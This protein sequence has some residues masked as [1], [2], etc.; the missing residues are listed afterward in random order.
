M[1]AI[2]FSLDA[3]GVSGLSAAFVP[4][5]LEA[6]SDHRKRLF[7]RCF[8]NFRRLSSFCFFSVAF[9]ICIRHISAVADELAKRIAGVA[10]G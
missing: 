8:T 10:Q 9:S 3:K 1:A 2:L 6:A 4:V 7:H 5:A